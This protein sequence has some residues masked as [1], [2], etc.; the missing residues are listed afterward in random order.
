MFIQYVEPP[1]DIDVAACASRNID[2][3]VVE[4]CLDDEDDTNFA[5]TRESS[6]DAASRLNK[7]DWKWINSHVRMNKYSVDIRKCDDILCCKEY[8]CA[9]VKEML[10]PFDGMKHL[11]SKLP[12]GFLPPVI[13]NNVENSFIPLSSLVGMKLGKEDARLATPDVDCPSVA[14]YQSLLCRYCATYYPM[15]KMKVLHE[16]KCTKNPRARA[17]GN[18]VRRRR[19]AAAEAADPL[20]PRDVSDRSRAVVDYFIDSESEASE[21]EA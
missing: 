11:I 19:S 13:K 14:D 4:T 12:S 15:K 17:G 18:T 7:K 5:Y 3:E 21:D 1:T 16:K 6:D 10:A 2:E 9:K 20:V 8:R